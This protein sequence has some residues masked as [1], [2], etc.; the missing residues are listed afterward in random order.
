MKDPDARVVDLRD[1]A[2]PVGLLANR[3]DRVN[4]GLR[5]PRDPV[6]ED[7]DGADDDHRLHHDDR[8][9]PEADVPGGGVSTDQH[10]VAVT[11]AV[12]DMPRQYPNALERSSI[13]YRVRASPG[14]R[15]TPCSSPRSPRLAP[16]PPSVL[17]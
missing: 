16:P 6:G 3:L 14:S 5:L 7:Q 10:S 9:Q 1:A 13:L 12:P 11:R 2:Q 8:T 15:R 4:C 17:P